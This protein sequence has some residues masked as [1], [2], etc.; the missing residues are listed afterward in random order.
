MNVFY[1]NYI[2]AN[3]PSDIKLKLTFALEKDSEKSGKKN[4]KTLI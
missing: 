3:F 1:N 2:V 4:L